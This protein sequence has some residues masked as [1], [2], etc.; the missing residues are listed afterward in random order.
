MLQRRKSICTELP[1]SLLT[2]TRVCP[3]LLSTIVE[4]S[5]SFLFL[6]SVLRFASPSLCPEPF[7]IA[8][9]ACKRKGAGVSEL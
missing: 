7:R 3:L 8:F 4:L 9:L 5:V 1:A 2:L 6:F